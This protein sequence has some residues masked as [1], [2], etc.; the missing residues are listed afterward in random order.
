[1]RFRRQFFRRASRDGA[2]G[3]KISVFVHRSTIG[4]NP[5]ADLQAL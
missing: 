2:R 1:M 3:G 5:F 4:A